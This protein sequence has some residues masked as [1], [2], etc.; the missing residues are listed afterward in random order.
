MLQILLTLSP[1]LKQSCDLLHAA[2]PVSPSHYNHNQ[3]TTI[4]QL[5]QKHITV[6]QVTTYN[7]SIMHKLYCFLYFYVIFYCVTVVLLEQ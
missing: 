4:I 1:V 6:V 2:S 3:Q 5:M 7:A